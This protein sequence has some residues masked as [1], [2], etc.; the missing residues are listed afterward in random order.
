MNYNIPVTPCYVRSTFLHDL[1]E[2]KDEIEECTVFGFTSIQGS[3]LLF[4]ALLSSGAFFMH[5]PLHAFCWKKDAPQRELGDLEL[6]DSF[7]YNAHIIE[8]K[9]LSGLSMLVKTRSG[10]E[11]GNYMFS[12]D[13]FDM[14]PNIIKTGYAEVPHEHKCAH[15]IRLEDGNFAAQPNNRVI[16]LEPSAVDF[17]GSFPKVSYKSNTRHWSVE[18]DYFQVKKDGSFD[19]TPTDETMDKKTF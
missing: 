17:N 11:R 5:L 3:A 16:F 7:S 1:Q 19:Y 13:W 14:E 10:E 2:K 9:A 4:S 6:W 8:F 18:E 12:I 15:I